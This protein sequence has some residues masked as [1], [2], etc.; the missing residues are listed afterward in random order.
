MKGLYNYEKDGK[1]KEEYLDITTTYEDSLN[2]CSYTMIGCKMEVES[3]YFTN[4][5]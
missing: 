1:E 5:K 2:K 3:Y 4:K